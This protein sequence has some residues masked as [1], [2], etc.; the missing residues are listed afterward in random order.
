MKILILSDF[1]PGEILGGGGLIGYEFHTLLIKKGFQSLF[2][3]TSSKTPVKDGNSVAMRQKTTSGRITSWV[4]GI[5]SISSFWFLFRVTREYKPDLIWINQIGNKWPITSPV[6]FRILRVKTIY[7]FHDFLVLNRYKISPKDNK[8]QL[9]IQKKNLNIS[10]TFGS[11]IRRKIAVFAVNQVNL[12]VTLTELQKKI[13][14]LYG[15][16]IDSVIPNGIHKCS[17]EVPAIIKSD[18]KLVLFAGRKNSKGL[19]IIAESVKNSN[20]SW[21]LVLA[22]G[23]ELDDY[24]KKKLSSEEFEYLGNLTRSEI[25]KVIHQIDLLAVLSQYYDPFP[26]IALESIAHG[27]FFITTNITGVATLYKEPDF[28]ELLFNL[29][30]I[31]DLDLIFKS[32]KINYDK[33]QLLEIND[34]ESVI[35]SYITLIKSLS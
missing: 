6:L 20:K 11:K 30:E 8:S 27:K 13:L 23:S 4:H 26:T 19:E 10:N 32:I 34:T 12:N 21:K 18:R 14:N 31:P 7:T 33:I 9:D 1:H 35:D 16:R 24:C 28:K 2:C 3:Y 29:E 17:C 22:G 15:V 25:F 5:F